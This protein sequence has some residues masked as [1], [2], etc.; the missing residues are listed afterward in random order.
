MMYVKASL[1]YELWTAIKYSRQAWA[2]PMLMIYLVL[3]HTS[4][5][6]LGGVVLVRSA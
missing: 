4:Y 1:P 5:L 2:T 6:L 3:V